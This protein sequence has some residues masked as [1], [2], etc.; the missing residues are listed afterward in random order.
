MP[1]SWKSTV[2]RESN[3]MSKGYIRDTCAKFRSKLE[4]CIL[5]QRTDLP[6]PCTTSARKILCPPIASVLRA[7]VYI[8]TLKNEILLYYFKKGPKI[9]KLGAF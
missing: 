4:A 9:I 1:W 8:F 2:D 6:R 7:S 5:A 3:S